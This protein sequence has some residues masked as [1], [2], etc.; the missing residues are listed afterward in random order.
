MAI[1]TEYFP[2]VVPRALNLDVTLI[3]TANI[4]GRGAE[5]ALVAEA[6]EE[7]P[8]DGAVLAT[9]LFTFAVAYS[10]VWLRLARFEERLP[11]GYPSGRVTPG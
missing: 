10:S 8:S 2:M 5:E 9:K 4:Y 6:R 11:S 1:A 3:A 7:V